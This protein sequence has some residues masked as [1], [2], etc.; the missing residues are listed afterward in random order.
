MQSIYPSPSFLAR[1]SPAS[2]YRFVQNNFPSKVV[3]LIVAVALCAFALYSLLRGPKRKDRT[4]PSPANP[5]VTKK[6]PQT[7]ASL[8]T[9]TNVTLFNYD[10]SCSRALTPHSPPTLDALKYNLDQKN[11]GSYKELNKGPYSDT[12]DVSLYRGMD[13]EDVHVYEVEDSKSTYIFVLIPHKPKLNQL[14]VSKLMSKEMETPIKKFS[15]RNGSRLMT[16]SHGQ[17]IIFEKTADFKR[18]GFN[19]DGWLTLNP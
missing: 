16:Y 10:I 13:V 18:V 17:Y 9:S 1:F 7:T 15:P 4:P 19:T 8:P 6:E 12:F 5:I 3:V 2:A 11:N 14:E